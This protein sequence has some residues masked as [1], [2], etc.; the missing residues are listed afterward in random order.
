MSTNREKAA[1]ILEDLNNVSLMDDLYMTLFFNDDIPVT[2]LLLRI[3]MNKDDLI[4]KS[5]STQYKINGAEEKRI[6]I[7]DVFATDSK[8]TRYDIEFQKE[9]S[10]ASPYRARFNIALLDS[11]ALKPTQDHKLLE[12][13]KSVVIFI[14]Q[15]DY[16]KM[17]RPLYKF[18]RVD[19]ETGINFNDGTSIIYVNGSYKGIDT[20]IG[21]LIHDIT[22]I[23]ESEM[24]YKDFAD[25]ANVVKLKRGEENMSLLD[26]L[27]KEEKAES[28]AEGK[29]EGLAEGEANGEAKRS[30]YVAAELIKLGNM[31]FETI[32]RVC[33]MSLV[34]VQELAKSLG[35]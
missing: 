31:T 19:I 25:R 27:L 21:R 28:R 16:F 23:K 13:N 20:A 14:T 18:E 6:A 10:G 32:A 33:K 7:F 5:V 26:D 24:F 22:C 3:V 17:G 11:N 8:G 2:Q 4:V 12:N 30:R 34:N 35:R 9:N 29:A 15:K 1:K